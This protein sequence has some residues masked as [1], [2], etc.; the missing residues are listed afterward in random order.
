MKLLNKHI[1]ELEKEI[2][3]LQE[4]RKPHKLSLEDLF[5]EVAGAVAVAFTMS[6]SEEIWELSQKLSWWHILAIFFLILTVA[7]FFVLYGNRKSW[8]KQQVLG[9]IQL[10]LLTTAVISIV[11]A[12][13][14]VLILG[15]YPTMVGSFQDYLKIVIFVASFSIIGGLGL[16]MARD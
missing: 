15:I 10:R 8:A 4:D 11:I 12:A 5:Q 1:E 14:V 16:D 6:L 2:E 9:F 3:K 13:V 7:N